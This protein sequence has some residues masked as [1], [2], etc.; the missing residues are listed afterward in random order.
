MAHSRLRAVRLAAGSISIAVALV[1]CQAPPPSASVQVTTPAVAQLHVLNMDG[2][3]VKVSIGA[4][5]VVTVHCG[6]S[7]TVAPSEVPPWELVVTD[8]SGTELLRQVLSSALDQGVVI[9]SDG[10]H[11]GEWPVPGGP[12]PAVTCPAS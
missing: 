4:V 6:E 3:T 9:R 12:A 10:A 7:T 8:A 2:P 1:S 11:A 5:E